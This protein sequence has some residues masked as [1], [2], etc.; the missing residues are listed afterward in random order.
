M[1]LVAV[2]QKYKKRL[3]LLNASL[4]WSK[5]QLTNPSRRQRRPLRTSR[6]LL[7][8][9]SR[10][11]LKASFLR[12]CRLLKPPRSKSLHWGFATPDLVRKFSQRL[13]LQQAIMRP[14]WSFLEVFAHTS[15]KSS[16]VRLNK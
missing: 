1:R 5:L 8:T 4:R 7:I 13:V 6:L 10:Q 14:R 11:L 2:S 9:K 3:P 15:L 12:T 16:K